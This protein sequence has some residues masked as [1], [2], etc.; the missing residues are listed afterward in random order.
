MPCRGRKD[1][2]LFRPMVLSGDWRPDPTF[3][4]ILGQGIYDPGSDS[5]GLWGLVPA[6]MLIGHNHKISAQFP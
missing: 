2:A 5:R 3:I 6:G 4:Y 1:E